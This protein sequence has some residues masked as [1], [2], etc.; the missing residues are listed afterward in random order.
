[1]AHVMPLPL[2]VS[3]FSKIQ[4]GFTFLVPAH[5][6][7]PWKGALNGF[8]YVYVCV[9]CVNWTKLVRTADSWVLVRTDVTVVF[10]VAEEVVEWALSAGVASCIAH[11]ALESLYGKKQAHVIVVFAVLILFWA[12][13]RASGL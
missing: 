7:S 4:V 10:A 1:M 3:C 6:G 8:V 9:L 13:G 11:R 12:V 5:P 2:T